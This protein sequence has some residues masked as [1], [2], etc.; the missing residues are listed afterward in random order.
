[1]SKTRIMIVSDTHGSNM[2][3][4]K[5]LEEIGN[6]DLFLHLGDLQG[7]EYF[8]ETFVESSKEMIA[9]N[10]DY[11]V[12]YPQ[13]KIIEVAGHR[14]WMTHG[15]LYQVYTGVSVL[16]ENAIKKGVD[17][18]LFGHTHE[19]YLEKEEII[20]LNPGSISLPRQKDRI[21]TYAVMEI[22]E[23]GEVVIDIKR[24]GQC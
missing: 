3:L 13:E 11:Y 20:I 22:D 5:A 2:Y 18:V 12:R 17:M 14:I 10:N 4:N 15:H 1:M 21:P 6:F 19:P 9:G 7:S 16:R 23:Q 24:V 8:I